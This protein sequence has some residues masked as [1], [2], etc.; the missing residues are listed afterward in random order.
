MGLGTQE[1]VAL[2]IVTGVVAFALYRRWR[3]GAS[4]R[5][6]CSGCADADESKETPVR[7]YRRQ[8]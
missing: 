6:G 5:A 7:F 2:L 8:D 3:R 1:I 4:K